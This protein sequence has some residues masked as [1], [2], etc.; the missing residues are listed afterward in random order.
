[1]RKVK[2]ITI[3]SK[4]K[5]LVEELKAQRDE[6]SVKL[7]LDNAETISQWEYMEAKW[8]EMEAK[9][10]RAGYSVG[11]SLLLL[12]KDLERIGGEL[13]DSFALLNQSQLQAA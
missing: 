7:N 5:S 12:D 3:A 10:K 1:M 6:L 2:M 8:Q 9:Y 4:A 11:K 13:R